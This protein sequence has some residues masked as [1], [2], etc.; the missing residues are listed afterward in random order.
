[1]STSA[2]AALGKPL[3]GWRLRLYTIIFE[4]DTRAGRLFDQWLIAVILASVVA[5][6]A[7][8]IVPLPTW[9]LDVLIAG[10]DAAAKQKVAQLVSDGGWSLDLSQPVLDRALF[11]QQRQAAAVVQ[12]HRRGT[13]PI[14]AGSQP[15]HAKGAPVA[16]DDPEKFRKTVHLSSIHMD[17]GMQCVDCHFAQDAHGN[18]FVGALENCE[19]RFA[20]VA[21]GNIRSGGFD[22]NGLWSPWYTLHKIFAGLR[23]AF[24]NVGNRDAL[25]TLSGL[26][27]WVWTRTQATDTPNVRPPIHRIFM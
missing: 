5:V 27:E 25:L 16:D 20:E 8:M 14:L 21:K 1:M 10:D 13:Y 9:L 15:S 19:A 7:M 24:V 3:Q 11:H 17:I 22:L 23:D 6:V 26:T 4:A 18:G 2:D 12:R